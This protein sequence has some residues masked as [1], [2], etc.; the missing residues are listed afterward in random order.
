[1][2]PPKL[3]AKFWHFL[4][5]RSNALI[6]YVTQKDEEPLVWCGGF[7]ATGDPGRKGPYQRGPQIGSVGLRAL[8][9]PSLLAVMYVTRP[10]QQTVVHSLAAY[11][12]K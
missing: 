8:A 4:G 3:Y 12:C 10:S 7:S 1:M 6:R 11:F 9:L 2:G 5:K